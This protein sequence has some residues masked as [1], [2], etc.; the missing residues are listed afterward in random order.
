MAYSLDEMLQFQL[1]TV[2]AN[3]T[4]TP[5]VHVNSQEP[6]YV[7]EL[8]KN[9]NINNI[10]KNKRCAFTQNELNA[11]HKDRASG[12]SIRKL[13]LKY[14]KSDKTIQKYLKITEL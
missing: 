7:Y 9:I 11:L 14:N 4:P 6:Y 5:I 8:L 10:N 3:G 2:D 13:A 1:Y 12:L